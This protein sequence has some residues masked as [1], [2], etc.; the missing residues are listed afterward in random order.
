[1][2]IIICKQ[3]QCNFNSKGKKKFCSHSCSA[4][5]NNAHRVRKDAKIVHPCKN[6]GKGNKNKVF[7]SN[8]C[9]AE[10]TSRSLYEEF[11]SSVD[12]RYSDSYSPKTFKPFILEEQDCRCSICEME[13]KWNG[14]EIIF[15]LDH[16]DGNSYNN[17]RENLRLVCPNC[18]SQLPTFKSKNKGKG[19]YYRRQRMLEGKSF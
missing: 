19:R 2:E 7:C 15:V 16:I 11:K 8:K 5:Y 1:M 4:K 17:N 14:K 9:Q 18:D 3:C 6:C 12:K 10:Y 13:N